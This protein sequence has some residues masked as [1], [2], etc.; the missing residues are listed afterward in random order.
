MEI[1]SLQGDINS[2]NEDN[3]NNLICLSPPYLTNNP[4]E[5][6]SLA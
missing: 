2:G 1:T 5:L 3:D 4:G 6:A